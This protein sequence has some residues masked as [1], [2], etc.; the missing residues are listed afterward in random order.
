MLAIGAASFCPAVVF[1]NAA[2][3]VIISNFSDLSYSPRLVLFCVGLFVLFTAISVPLFRRAQFSSPACLV[4]QILM[5]IGFCVLIFGV[6][7]PLLGA[8][9]ITNPVALLIDAGTLLMIGIFVT[10]A[11][12][13]AVCGLAAPL[14][15]GLIIYTVVSHG[16]ALRETLV[17]DIA[18]GKEILPASTKPLP[19]GNIYHIVLDGFQ[20]EVYEFLAH[21]DQ[22]LN[23][24][25]FV[26]Y[27]R[28]TS[29]YGT[30][31]LSLPNLLTGRILEEEQSILDWQIE[32]TSGGL[33]ADLAKT[34]MSLTLYPYFDDECPP[35]I[36]YCHPAMA[37][38]MLDEEDSFNAPMSNEERQLVD[39]WFVLL[40][41]RSLH[42][43]TAPK[44]DAN[45]TEVQGGG[46]PDKEVFSITTFFWGESKASN[47]A[48][49][50]PN[51]VPTHNRPAAS[52]YNFRQMLA[53]EA[54]RPGQG[55]YVYVHAHLPHGPY[56]L[57]R[58][59]RPYTEEPA[60]LQRFLGQSTCGI[61]L[62]NE[63][64]AKLKE[65]GRF[66]DSLIV[67]HSDHGAYPLIVITFGMEYPGTFRPETRYIKPDASPPASVSH[68]PPAGV[69]SLRSGAL[70][71]VKQPGASES[72]SSEKDVQMIDLAPTI[73]RYAGHDLDGYPG[74]PINELPI[75]LL[76]PRPFYNYEGNSFVPLGR[77]VFFN[78]N[79]GRPSIFQRAVMG[80]KKPRLHEFTQDSSGWHYRGEITVNY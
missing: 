9:S 70:L 63:L 61:G 33:W 11:P 3:S 68:K 46:D 48:S 6:S 23:L 78:V 43:L 40:L 71:L 26:F 76:R 37:I 69:P 29:A 36:G 27:P 44:T 51:P 56:T 42:L 57:A 73:L 75:D 17:S 13:R 16:S 54:E 59:C 38:G 18:R 80:D 66:D 50:V 30:T 2:N 74:Y 10:K 8:A 28:F 25:E 53:D 21:K 49:A 32:A 5:T 39:L 72:S 55:Q 19:S 67:V 64:L 31:R 58:D 34:G 79:E 60:A 4:S 65:L 20:R 15:V 7:K 41:P 14:S 35:N 77:R 62:V 45:T 47:R 1:I 52:V 24:S 12:C 22:D